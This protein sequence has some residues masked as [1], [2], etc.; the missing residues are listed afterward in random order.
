[1]PSFRS[2]AALENESQADA[3]RRSVSATNGRFSSSTE[4]SVRLA[5]PCVAPVTGG[6]AVCQRAEQRGDRLGLLP[7]L[8]RRG[9]GPRHRA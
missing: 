9:R 7:P 4:S 8:L 6:L 1:M 3:Q 5:G 2:F